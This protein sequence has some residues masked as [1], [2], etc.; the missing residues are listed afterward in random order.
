[1]INYCHNYLVNTKVY[2]MVNIKQE[3]SSK[4]GIVIYI[5]IYIFVYILIIYY[6]YFLL[7]N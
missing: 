2:Q 7:Q 1:M 6:I 3:M 4:S 5:Y